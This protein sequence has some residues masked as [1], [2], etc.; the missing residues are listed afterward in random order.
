M[1][2]P[3]GEYQV[4]SLSIIYSGELFGGYVEGD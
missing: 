4:V 3:I 1:T 2:K